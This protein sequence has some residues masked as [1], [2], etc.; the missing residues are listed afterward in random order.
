MK[1]IILYSI[2]QFLVL[3]VYS[4]NITIIESTSFNPGHDMD[5]EWFNVSNSMGHSP[6]IMP[7]TTLDNNAFFATTDILIISSGVITLTPTRVATILQFLQTGKPVYL[8]CEYQAIYSSNITFAS[9]IS[10]LGGTFNW[11]TP[12]T[13]DL[14]PMN[15]LGTHST[16][17]NIVPSIDYF[18]YS[19][20]GIG[21][22]NT[23]NFLQYGGGY[24]GFQFIPPNPA[25][26]TIAATTDQDWVRATTS[27]ALMENIITHLIAPPLANGASFNLG[28]DT[29][30]CVGQ[31]LVL[32]ATSPSATYLWQNGST[33]PTLSVTIPGTYWVTVTSN[34][35]SSTDTIQVNFINSIPLNLGNDTTIC[36]GATLTLNATTTASSYLWQNGSTNPL[37]NVNLP[38]TYYVTV[39]NGS[40]SASDTIQV[41]YGPNFTINLGNDT[42]LCAGQS[43]N[44]NATYPSATYSWQ[45]GSTNATFPVSSAGI[46]WVAV[47]VGFCVATDTIQINYNPYPIINL[48]P[49]TSICQGQNILFNATTPTASYLWQN[50]TTNATLN[51]NLPGTYWVNVTVNNCTSSDSIQLS[52]IPL[53][54]V[55]LGSDT[56]LCQGQSFILNATTL[57]ATYQWQ[58]SS[59]NSTFNVTQAGNYNVT[60]TVNNCSS[61]DAINIQY[62]A[63]T[64]INLGNDT[65]A[66]VGDQINLNAFTPS[67][68]YVWQDGNT[69]SNYN[70]TLTGT[71][72]VEV[73]TGACTSSDTILL[74]FKPNPIIDL[75][76]DTTLCDGQ[77]ILLDA[78]TINGTYLWHDNTT[79]ATYN[80]NS[81]GTYAVTVSVDNCSTTDQIEIDYKSLP[82]VDL[83]NDTSICIGDKITLDATYQDATY[84]WQDN[85]IL[86]TYVI[87]KDGNYW[88]SL[89]NFCGTATD[90]INVTKAN[91]NCKIYIPNVFTPN[92][93]NINDN[94]K[95][96]MNCDPIEYDLKIFNRWGQLVF[97]SDLVSYGWNGQFNGADASSGVYFYMLSYKYSKDERQVSNGDITLLR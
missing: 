46:Y 43:Y 39:N 16:T 32:N 44:L 80:V 92:N 26:G 76:N 65:T 93:D 4:L 40:C 10:S 90:T 95:P 69:L 7:Q 58:D 67:A 55:N 94:F 25:Y 20:S 30:L 23:V 45:N 11:S 9:L 35:C 62:Q 73:K 41:A 53:P 3:S 70:A 87:S 48:G 86:P 2:F 81:A 96:T 5:S 33:N 79:N 50:S 42:S 68:T 18:W 27:V 84:L 1:K 85:S 51:A 6:S 31:T 52:I 63:P 75:G 54:I 97:E 36:P 28:N 24:H 14:I 22:C 88:V 82:V 17:N 61:N 47:N 74:V 56:V 77:T 57:N 37:L 15:V 89:T 12:F 21:D 8:Q 91:C 71:Y 78:T 72:W 60:V 59:T 19:V 13:G 34:G 83:G 64:P 29:T 66:C 49:D 38:G